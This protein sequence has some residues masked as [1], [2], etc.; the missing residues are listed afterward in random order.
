M[1]DIYH[2]HYVDA[3]YIDISYGAKKALGETRLIPHEAYGYM[4]QKKDTLIIIFIRK[5]HEKENDEG[6]LIKGLVLPDTALVSVVKDF[7]NDI[8]KN[9]KVGSSVSL[10]WRDS[11]FV[12]NQPRY[13]CSEMLTE[14]VLYRVEKDHIVIQNPVTRR[15]HPLPT[16]NH[17]EEKPLYYIIPISFITSIS[18]E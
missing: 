16:K 11:V 13:D 8:I 14:G 7:G 5:K 1:N 4:Y 6:N 3:Y 12:A 15:T 17:P 9:I 18:N 10:T 2:I